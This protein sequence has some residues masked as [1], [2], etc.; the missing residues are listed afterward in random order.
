MKETARTLSSSLCVLARP[1]RSCI[2]LRIRLCSPG[3]HFSPG[4]N[5]AAWAGGRWQ[6]LAPR[7]IETADCAFKE[8][9]VA[10]S[11]SEA[12]RRALAL[13]HLGEACPRETADEVQLAVVHRASVRHPGNRIDWRHRRH[14]SRHCVTAGAGSASSERPQYFGR[15][16]TRAALRM[17]TER[18]AGRGSCGVEDAAPG[19]PCAKSAAPGAS[20]AKSAAPGASCAKGAALGGPCTKGAAL[21]GPCTKGAAL[22]VPSAKG[23]AAVRHRASTLLQRA[24]I[25]LQRGVV[26]A[27]AKRGILATSR[28]WL[29]VVLVVER[30]LRQVEQ[31]AALSGCKEW[32]L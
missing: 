26:F 16:R 7:C 32:V 28:A 8:R 14:S 20:C 13:A 22:G 9:V 1:A 4:W 21:G 19:V 11:A 2:G 24:V 25:P 6:T 15:G 3:I 23:A 31:R 27:S 30:A 17:R 12:W 18:A 5:P 29:R 10:R